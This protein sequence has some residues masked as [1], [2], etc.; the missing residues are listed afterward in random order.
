M[1]LDEWHAVIDVNLSGVFHCCK[2]GL[3]ILRDGGAIVNMGS[4]A[5]EAGFH[6]QANYAAAKAGVQA[7]TRVLSRESARRASGSTQSRPGLIETPMAASIP[8]AA[9]STMEKSIPRAGLVRPPKWPRPSSSSA[10]PWPAISPGILSQ[11][12]AAGGVS[13]HCSFPRQIL[14]SGF[15]AAHAL[16]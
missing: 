4:L 11:S 12:T 16:Q 9:R 3:E 10:R 13:V 6:G 5:A 8:A 7:L 2:Y 15:P 14:G 1:T